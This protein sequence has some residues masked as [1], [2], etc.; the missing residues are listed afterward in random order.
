MGLSL[1]LSHCTRPNPFALPVLLLLNLLHRLLKAGLK[2][3][4]Y[5]CRIAPTLRN[6]TGIANSMLTEA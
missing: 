6:I 4:N 2:E 3:S 5:L 1:L